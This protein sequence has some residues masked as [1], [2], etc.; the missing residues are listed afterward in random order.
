[1]TNT[2]NGKLFSI[3]SPVAVI[4][5]SPVV[6]RN[7]QASLERCFRQTTQAFKNKTRTTRIK[8]YRA[9][10][11]QNGLSNYS[12]TAQH[13][14]SGEVSVLWRKRHCHR[15]KCGRGPGHTQ[16]SL[17][18]VSRMK[19]KSQRQTMIG[20]FPTLRGTFRLGA[21]KRQ[22]SGHLTLR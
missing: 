11:T 17:S 14:S 4:W 12:S 18:S 3:A 15:L 20:A 7:S 22:L 1:M 21:K 9:L 8:S 5:S 19:S 6:F 13:W 2:L 16:Y 10:T